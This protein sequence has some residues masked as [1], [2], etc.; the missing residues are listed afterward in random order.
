M[1]NWTVFVNNLLPFYKEF[2]ER[3]G[4][5][6]LV[7][8]YAQC[9]QI[10]LE[11]TLEKVTNNRHDPRLGAARQRLSRQGPRILR[12]IRTFLQGYLTWHLCDPWYRLQELHLL[13]K[14]SAVVPTKLHNYLQSAKEVGSVDPRTWEY[15]SVASLAAENATN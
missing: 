15:P 11:E 13:T 2:D 6:S 5:T 10:T 4:Q 8:N 9:N 12:P 3:R 7:K 1:E 14:H